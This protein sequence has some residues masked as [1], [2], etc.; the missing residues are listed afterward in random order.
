MKV[1]GKQKKKE[2][3][4]WNV[5]EGKRKKVRMNKTKREVK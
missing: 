3:K 2:E 1:C 5:K 4:K